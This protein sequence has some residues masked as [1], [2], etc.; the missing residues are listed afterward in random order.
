M[1]L[2]SSGFTLIE[3]IIVVILLALCVSLLLG[4]NY[5][6]QDSFR[7]KKD[8]RSLYSFFLAARSYALLENRDNECRY[9]PESRL[10]EESLRK[11]HMSLQDG[12][13]INTNG[14]D[15][16]EDQSVHLVTFF[17]DGSAGSGSVV[18]KAGEKAI[19]LRIDP[20]LGS[21][22]LAAEGS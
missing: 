12:I 8:S 4:I 17:S 3:I 19:T 6:Q 9:F 13:V 22:H 20:V 21:V 15:M 11:K 7:L 2:N 1:R 16:R 14:K 5:S 10:I 18:M